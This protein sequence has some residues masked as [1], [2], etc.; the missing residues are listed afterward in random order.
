[1]RKALSVLFAAA[2]ALSSAGTASAEP[3]VSAQALSCAAG[4][5]CVWPTF[6]G[7]GS[8]CSWSANSPDWRAWCSW[9]S[10][11][12]VRVAYNNKTN[13]NYDRVC[14][15]PAT[16]Y[17]GTPIHIRSGTI[18]EGLNMIVR[19]HRWGINTC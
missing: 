4:N 9:S 12:P 6:D 13:T 14:L 8:R 18:G 15:Y 3:P 5:L 1:M 7:T 19:S 2:F 11:R 17:R 16:N 10:S